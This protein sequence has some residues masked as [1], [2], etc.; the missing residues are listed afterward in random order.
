MICLSIL[1]IFLIWLTGFITVMVI[2]MKTDG[3]SGIYTVAVALNSWL[4]LIGYLLLKL[5]DNL[6]L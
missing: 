4:G 2:V 5:T 6:D 1:D 3:W